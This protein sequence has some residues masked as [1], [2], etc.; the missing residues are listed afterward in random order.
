MHSVPTST[1]RLQLSKDFTFA[2]ARSLLPYLRDLGI[3]WIYLSPVLRST[4]GSTHGYD[5]VDP[6]R[7]DEDRGGEA[8]FDALCRDAHRHGLGVLVDIVPNHVGVGRPELNPWW[9]AVLQQGR[10]SRYASTFDID[11]PAGGDKVLLPV[12]GDDDVLPDG[13]VG[14][15]RIEGGELRYRDHR[16]PLAS[17]RAEADDDPNQVLER[18]HYALRSWRE[19]ATG[20]NYRRFFGV[21]SLAAVRVEDLEVFEATHAQVRRWFASGLVDGLRVD[22]PDGLR[23]PRGYLV[24]LAD[25]VGEGYLVVEKILEPGEEL[26][27]SW[28]VHGTTGYEALGL[29]DRVLVDPVGAG[30]LAA[31]DQQLR[32]RPGEWAELLHDSKLE[33]TRVILGSEVRRLARELSP[34]LPGAD[35]EQLVAALEELLACFPVYRSYLPDGAHHLEKAAG[36]ATRR[37]PELA[38]VIERVQVPLSTPTHPAALRFQQT[39][40]MVMAKGAEDRAFY[41]WS[42][43]TSLDEVG[44]DPDV[45]AI[46]VPDFHATMRE[47]LLRCPDAM[48]TTSTHDTKRGEDVRARIDALAELPVWWSETLRC[49]LDAVPV[50]DEGLG[51]LLWQAI[52][53]CWPASEERLAAYAQKAMRE[54]GQQ[55]TWTEPDENFESAVQAAVRAAYGNPAV[56]QLLDG[57]ANELAPYGWSNA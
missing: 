25:L 33:V 19:E 11:W 37:R 47:R 31:L 48:T 16:F 38:E 12:L 44:G 14:N 5:V 8:S 18:Q 28:P 1:Y 42:P 50:P 6:T 43:L 15:L 39:S 56:H 20:L 52:V 49:L 9:W 3:D 24:L 27:S 17:G 22:H 4:P 10:D 57:A 40:G 51:N 21:S 46:T 54:A 30:A 34:D 45:L 53:G 35:H 29:I 13:T 36:E 32:A 23:H 2:D 41:R 26:P 7:I 55:T